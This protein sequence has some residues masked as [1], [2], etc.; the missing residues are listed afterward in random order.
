MSRDDEY[1]LRQMAEHGTAA[2]RF[3]DA[4]RRL[5][6]RGRVVRCG[7][8]FE[9]VFDQASI[10]GDSPES[11]VMDWLEDRLSEFFASC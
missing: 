2:T 8:E 6:Q 5:G 9:L 1:V 4:Q 3:F 10:V 7:V 11:V